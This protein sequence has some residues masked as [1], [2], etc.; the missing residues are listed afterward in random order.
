[1]YA[2]TQLSL[3]TNKLHPIRQNWAAVLYYFHL[4]NSFQNPTAF[5]F[6]LL[7]GEKDTGTQ[8]EGNETNKSYLPFGIIAF[9]S[10]QVANNFFIAGE[11]E[12]M[13]EKG[14]VKLYTTGQSNYYS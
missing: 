9:H 6:V 2:Y 11:K 8:F 4:A 3:T 1:M 5:H 13:K 7:D 10:S 12:R 14:S